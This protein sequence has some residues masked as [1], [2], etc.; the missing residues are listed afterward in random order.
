[1]AGRSLRSRPTIIV[2][3]TARTQ[4]LPHV[5]AGA[6]RG[7]WPGGDRLECTNELASAYEISRAGRATNGSA[8]AA[9]H[10]GDLHAVVDSL[11]DEMRAGPR[12]RTR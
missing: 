9:A 12:P 5:A 8:V 1:M 3:E 4:P 2:D 6:A 7:P 11:V 10:G